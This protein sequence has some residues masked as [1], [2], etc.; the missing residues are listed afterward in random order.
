VNACL[1]TYLKKI[2]SAERKAKNRALNDN[3]AGI[4]TDFTVCWNSAVNSFRVGYLAAEILKKTA[5][6]SLTI[7]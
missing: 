6:D 7:R 2:N 5:F 3:T 1:H 4:K